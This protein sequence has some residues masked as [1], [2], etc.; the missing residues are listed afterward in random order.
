[1]NSESDCGKK[2]VKATTCVPHNLTVI[3]LAEQMSTLIFWQIKSKQALRTLKQV[4][5][6]LLVLEICSRAIYT[7]HLY[8]VLDEESI[9][10]PT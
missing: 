9:S 7:L 5:D 6:F 4:N 10:L 8:C 2:T 1:M 3:Y